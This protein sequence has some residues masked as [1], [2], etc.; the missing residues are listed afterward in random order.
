MNPPESTRAGTCPPG[1]HV[2]PRAAE[3]DG[4][5]SSSPRQPER[6]RGNVSIINRCGD[7]RAPPVSRTKPSY[8][9]C[10]IRS[11][12]LR[13]S[14]RCLLSATQSRI[15]LKAKQLRGPRGANVRRT[16]E[17]SSAHTLTP[18]HLS[19]CCKEEKIGKRGK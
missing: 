19:I 16:A 17:N 7:E 2:P 8:F 9:I 12:R 14:P 5:H 15:S 11:D 1:C 18:R 3:A 13:R 10:V 6:E 4:S